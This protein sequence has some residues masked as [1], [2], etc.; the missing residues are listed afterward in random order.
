MSKIK[1][2]IQKMHNN[3]RDWKLD[4]LETI[5]AR[6]GIKIRKSGGSHVVFMHELS[7]RVITIPA[8]RPIK[9]IYIQQFLALINDIGVQNDEY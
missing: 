7:N 9:P 1:K 5:A 3:P 2:L 4:T 6:L 8:K